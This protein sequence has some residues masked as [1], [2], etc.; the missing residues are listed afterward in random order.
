MSD[1]NSCEFELRKLFEYDNEF[2]EI[3][4]KATTIISGHLW[5]LSILLG[6]HFLFL[7]VIKLI[8]KNRGRIIISNF[9]QE[10]M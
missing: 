1:S 7:S 6:N 5:N 4:D 2:Q 8:A 9:N 10:K 3:I